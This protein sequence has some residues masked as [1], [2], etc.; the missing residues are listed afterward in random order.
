MNAHI[1]TSEF[2]QLL[3]LKHLNSSSG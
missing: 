2:E 3:A 1:R